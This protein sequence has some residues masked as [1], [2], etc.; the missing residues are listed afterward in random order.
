MIP[1]HSSPLCLFSSIP[2]VTGL[3]SR[4]GWGE[5]NK[6]MDRQPKLDSNRLK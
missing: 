4:V 5:G 1:E 2:L 3:G 6:L